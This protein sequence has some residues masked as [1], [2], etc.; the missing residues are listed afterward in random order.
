MKE[1]IRNFLHPLVAFLLRIRSRPLAFTA[2]SRCVIIAPHQ[3]DEAFGC[4]GLIHSRRAA[5]LPVSI[6]Y[7]TDGAG[8]HPDHPH[9]SPADISQRRRA[10]A[11]QAMALLRV[12]SDSLHFFDAPDGSLGSIDPAAF[13]ALAQRL[14]PLLVSLQPTELLIPCRDDSSSEHTG[15]FSLTERALQLANLHPKVFEYPVWA[16]W[17]PQQFLKLGLAAPLLWRLSFPHAV[18]LKRTVLAAYVSQTEPT[19]PWTDPVLPRGFVR[20]F[21]PPEEFFFER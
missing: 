20:C 13:E 14:A 21:E 8:S 3:D 1:L 12:D 17:R 5:G 15:A 19:P 6:L 9:L 18:A 16:R 4:A 10:E 7:L 2:G 11:G